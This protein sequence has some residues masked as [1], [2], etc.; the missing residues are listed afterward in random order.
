MRVIVV[1]AGIGGLALGQALVR[2]GVDVSAHDR[3]PD[4]SVTGGYR[5][6]L[7]HRA[8]AVLRRRLSPALHQALLG[9]SADARTFRRFSFTDHRLNVL[10]AED[11]PSDEERLLVGRVPLRRLLTHGLGDSL[12]FGSEFTHHE[13][14]PD[15]RVAACF[16]DGRREVGDLLVGADGVGSR[17][18][19]AL[20]GRPT[21]RP[22][23][24][25][26]IA[27]R[28]RLTPELR[29]V[30]PAVL[31]SGAALAFA[32]DGLSSFLHVHDPVAGTAIDPAACVDVPADVEPAD[33]VW[34]VHGPAQ[35]FPADVRT[36]DDE[37]LRRVAADLMRDWH[38]ALRT[39]T[40]TP[41]LARA[42]LTTLATA[43]RVRHGRTT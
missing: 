1:G 17:V 19:S 2:Q 43:H 8:C 20:A 41:P 12:V 42:A 29:A 16:A 14:L 35:A 23:G 10:F 33:L 28:T 11:L 38:P 5:L 24:L 40:S 13:T 34:G 4:L 36:L 27:A 39:V 15:G 21:S 26:G 6:H 37:G 32:P 9:S 25:G 22:T 30:L 3:D 18:A 7:D 31:D